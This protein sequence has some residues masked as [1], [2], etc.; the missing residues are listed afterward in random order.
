MSPQYPDR[1]ARF[2]REAEMLAALNHPNIAHIHGLEDS[3]GVSALVMEFIDG[4]TLADRIVESPR[5]LPTPEIVAI[6]T[7]IAS[8]LESAHDRGIVHRDLKPANI[9][10]APGGVVKLLDFGLAKEFATSNPDSIANTIPDTTPRTQL[11]AIVGTAAYMSPEQALGEPVDARADLFSLGAVLYEMAT[12]RPAFDGAV[13]PAILDA[14]LHKTPTSPRSINPRVPP[15]LDR[16]VLLLL[17]KDR[18]A[19]AAACFRSCR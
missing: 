7:Q 14:V 1:I 8:A 3:N 9:K 11:G 15:A 13:L 2:Q 16:L 10:I 19:S 17:E 4:P 12:G 5:G 18:D 6:A